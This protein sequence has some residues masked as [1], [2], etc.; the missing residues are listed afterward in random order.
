MKRIKPTY[1]AYTKEDMDALYGTRPATSTLQTVECPDG[2]EA[3]TIMAGDTLRSIAT[4]RGITVTELLFYNPSLNPYG[5][6]R[7]DVICVPANSTAA[8]RNAARTAP[9]EDDAAPAE[10]EDGAESNGEGTMP[11]PTPSLPGGDD[12]TTPPAAEPDEDMQP[13]PSLPDNTQNNDIDQRPASPDEGPLPLPTPALPSPS[14]PAEPGEGPV[15]LPTPS[16]P[17]TPALPPTPRCPNGTLYTVR[18]GDTLRLIAQRFDVTLDAL[19]A[20]NPGQTNSRLIIGQKLCIPQPICEACCPAGT[21]SVRIQSTN[22]VDYLVNYNI[23]YAA[24]AAANPNLDLDRLIT[25]RQIC[26]PPI[27]SRG[28][29]SQG[30][31]TQELA[32]DLTAAELAQ[33]LRVTIAQ[34]MKYNPNYTPTDFRRGRI[35]CVPPALR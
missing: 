35:I 8:P 29:C 17:S 7:G 6:K 25:G 19:M 3:Y 10:T 13:T 31:G 18:S 33:Q 12:T 1:G 30:V 27:G 24:L 32:I 14:Q 16:V 20:A 34:L 22:F 9:A 15:P 5:Y 26:I 21:S 23:S 2:Y 4:S 11:L 28:N